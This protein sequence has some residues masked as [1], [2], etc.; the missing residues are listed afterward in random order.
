MSDLAARPAGAPSRRGRPLTPERWGESLSGPP[1]LSRSLAGRGALL[2]CWRGVAPD[3]VQP[4][5]DHHYL[6]LHLG[7]PKR[8]ARCGDGA[9][10]W[11][12][13]DAGALS[14]TPAGSAFTWTTRGPVEFA[15]L[16]LAPGALRRLAIEE[17]GS[18]RPP[19]APRLGFRDPLLRALVQAL[20]EAARDDAAPRA[21]IDALLLAVKLRLL[22]EGHGPAARQ[23]AGLAPSRLRRVVDF[24][25]ANLA[26]DLPLA[27]LAAVAASSP[28]HFSR[29]F[30]AATGLPPHA[31]I[32]RRR[33]ELAGALLADG[34]PPAEVAARCGCAGP[35]QLG[36][37][38][39]R[40]TGQGLAQHRRLAGR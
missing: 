35:A 1:L 28:W 7:G 33:V 21:Y 27:E 38:L 30:A 2:R 18:D 25:E 8:V 14:F 13:I 40:E 9:D 19:P 37:M 3:I 29:G 32:V 6:T 26:A 17:L 12:E 39:R 10:E 20:V 5:L 15:H 31:Y 22:T 4:S 23:R 11:V 34:V 16:Y 36:R 24:V